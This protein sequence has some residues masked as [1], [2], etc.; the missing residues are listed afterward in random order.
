MSIFP[1]IIVIF[2]IFRAIASSGAGGYDGNAVQRRGN[3]TQIPSWFGWF[4][5]KLVLYGIAWAMLAERSAMLDYALLAAGIFIFMPT[6]MVRSIFI[7]LGM[8][9]T[10]Y[11][12]FLCLRPSGYGKQYR[13][14]ACIAA[15]LALARKRDP[16]HGCAWLTE[17]LPQVASSHV[18]YDMLIGLL[19]AIRGER[20]T[21]RA[22]FHLIDTT[23]SPRDLRRTARDWLVA[24]AAAQGAWQEAIWRGKRGSDSFRWS[25]AV[26]RMIERIDRRAEAPADWLLILLWLRA[27]RR[28][29]LLPLL[30]QARAVPR[31]APDQAVKVSRPLSWRQAI[32]PLGAMLCEMERNGTPPQR[33]QFVSAIHGAAA[34]LVVPSMRARLEERLRNL[35]PNLSDPKNADAVTATVRAQLTQLA[36]ALIE[37]APQLAEG[38]ASRP[39]IGEAIEGMRRHALQDIETRSQDFARRSRERRAL[40]HMQ[41]W[42]AW[43][44]LRA[45]AERLLQIA[46]QAEASLFAAMYEPMCNFAVY[47]HNE[48]QQHRLAHDIFC[49]LH[50]HAACNPG[51]VE[52]L[53]KNA[54]AYSGMKKR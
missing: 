35:D 5:L 45:R 28:R 42:A 18:G 40:A 27:P 3:T 26:A 13:L 39:F 44:N 8:V 15:A 9:R 51:A 30:R 14:G 48:L 1:I 49:W 54:Q 20:D 47:Q 16:E 4:L 11:W 33:A 52:L 12:V 43:G 50:R 17:Q 32:A 19:A 7:P 25:Y 53:G 38:G 41:E 21:A 22:V 23:L 10:A 2:W 6:L 36:H 37:Q 29:R 34:N 46:P 31:R 24:E